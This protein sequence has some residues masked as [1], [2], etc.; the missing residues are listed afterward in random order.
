MLDELI[1]RIWASTYRLARSLGDEHS[2]D[3]LKQL[4]Q[5]PPV[6]LDEQAALLVRIKE[7]SHQLREQ[8]A[9]EATSND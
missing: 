3:Q 4:R 7:I 6:F 8:S 1:T 9:Q 5:H 2:M